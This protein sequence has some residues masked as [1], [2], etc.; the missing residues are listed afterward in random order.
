[1]DSTTTQSD[2]PFES[3]LER[4]IAVL[5]EHLESQKDLLV[6]TADKTDKG[7][8]DKDVQ[9]HNGITWIAC[10]WNSNLLLGASIFNRS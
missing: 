1:M 7:D 9:V 3:S 2:R 6:A 8:P 5:L 4:E 10:Y